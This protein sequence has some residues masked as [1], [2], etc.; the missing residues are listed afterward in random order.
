MTSF[1]AL[2]SQIESELKFFNEE[3]IYDAS[4]EIEL[5]AP[6]ALKTQMNYFETIPST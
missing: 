6:S 4:Q 3:E 2:Q 5:E 1:A